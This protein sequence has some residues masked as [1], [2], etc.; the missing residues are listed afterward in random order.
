MISDHKIRQLQQEAAQ[1]GD[2]MQYLICERA[3]NEDFDYEDYSGGGHRLTYSQEK[4]IRKMTQ[5]EARLMCE[6]AIAPAR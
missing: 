3:L 5:D 6:A 2:D 1:R 4:L